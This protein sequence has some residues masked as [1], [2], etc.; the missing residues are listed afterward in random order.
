MIDPILVS[1]LQKR[2]EGISEEMS[3][4]LKKSSYSPNI[5]ERE[6]FSCAIF[7]WQARLVAQAEAIPVHLGSFSFV[8][9]PV[10]E[11]FK[12]VWEEGDAIILN[13]PRAEFGGTH[14]PDISL[15]APVFHNGKLMFIVANRA[16]HADVG[17]MTPGSLPPKS[18]EIFQEGLIIPPVRL[19][20]KGKED[21]EIMSM[22]LENVRTPNERK[23]DLRAQ[24]SS[25]MIGV[26]R[27]KSILSEESWDFQTLT[28]AILDFSEQ[29]TRKILMKLPEGFGEFEDYLDNDGI[30][31]NQI[32]ISCR[33][34]LNKDEVIVN[35]QNS[36]AQSEGNVNAPF[37]ITTAAVYYVIRLICGRDVPT[38]E[39]CFRPVKIIAPK[40]S[41]VN[42]DRDRATSS[43]NTETSSRIVDTVIGAFS[44]II[45]MPA[46]S[47]GTMNNVIIGGKVGNDGLPWTI[48]ETIG[49]G[50]GAFHDRAG[51]SAIHTHMTNT[52]NTPVEALEIAYPLKVIRYGIR[53]GSGGKGRYSGGNGIVREIMMLIPATIT[54]QTERRVLPAWGLEGGGDGEKGQNILIK[55]NEEKIILNGRESINVDENDRILILTPGGGAYNSI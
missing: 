48:Y 36:D 24:Y 10:L 41:V 13:S 45:P 25:L 4:V 52:L 3:V 51:T 54:L 20:K 49:G 27:I 8:A 34:N 30:T 15:L 44:K 9:T 32:K 12:E 40:G 6:D 37:S 55:K 29:G 28:E 42:P 39:G 17:G 16:H 33:V 35:F 22:I 23:G 38:N 31:N 53:D 11:I 18:T 43:A 26:K 19:Y 7:D 46:A 1:V 2:L 47:Q 50:A 5:K 21:Q 14:L